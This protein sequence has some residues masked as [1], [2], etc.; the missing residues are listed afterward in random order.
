MGK[1]VYDN[2]K[3]AKKIKELSPNLVFVDN[4]T[5]TKD[6]LKHHCNICNGDFYA[7]PNNTLKGKGCPYCHNRKVLIGFNDMWTTNP[8]ICELLD[9][10]ND[11]YNYVFGTNKKIAF[12]CPSCGAI[13]NAK[14]VLAL[15][16]KYCSRCRDSISYPEKFMIALLNQTNI[17]Y[18]YQFTKVNQKWCDKY[19]Y[20]FYF[21]YNGIK[22]IVETNGIQHYEK[23]FS[24][25]GGQ[26]LEE[27]KI[28]DSVKKQLATKYID[29]YIVVDCRKSEYAYIANQILNSE[30]NTIFDLSHIDF[31]KCHEFAIDSLIVKVCADYKNGMSFIDI[32]AKYKISRS[33]LRHYLIE[34]NVIGLCEYNP[35]INQLECHASKIICLD[36]VQEYYSIIEAKRQ[37]KVSEHSIAQSC[38]YHKILNTPTIYKRWMY[39]DEYLEKKDNLPEY[40]FE[41]GNFSP[42]MCINTGQI[43]KSI[44][45]AKRWIGKGD[46]QA[47]LSGKQNTA[48][49]HPET[50]EKLLWQY[51]SGEYKGGDVGLEKE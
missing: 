32:M 33:G 4:Y 49:R 23:G 7:S 42:I 48:G 27:V 17:Q 39:Y 22:I 47:V 41:N 37:T 29:R 46:I 34:G 38:K 10:P 36:T 12:K 18:K 50:G 16:N 11:G 6:L 9:N 15:N 35:H 8:E 19:K 26:T 25:V 24:T 2:E 14:P 28:N 31:K 21:E 44:N 51:Y 3:Y 43:F 40:K 13:R 30:L 20:D 45:D 5:T 1:R